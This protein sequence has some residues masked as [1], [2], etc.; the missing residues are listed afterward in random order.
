MRVLTDKKGLSPVMASIV[1]C[2]V[3]LTVG[4]SV[5]SFTYSVSSAL[6]DDYWEKSL[7]NIDIISERF[8]VEH[9]AYDN[10]SG[11]I[12][13]W[14]YNYGD[15]DVNVTVLVFKEA[16]PSGVSSSKK[17][18]MRTLAP[19]ITISI[20]SWSPGTELLIKVNSLRGNEVYESYVY[21]DK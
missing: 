18:R 14:I 12:D 16:S 4:I 17:I 8:M 3:V 13:V 1:L 15:V 19:K 9:V 7:E 5:W 20:G 21:T 2:S 10:S 11:L 6:Q